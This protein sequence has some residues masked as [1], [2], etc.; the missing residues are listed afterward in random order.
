M[1]IFLKFSDLA[2]RNC[3][4]DIAEAA[5]NFLIGVPSVYDKI[6]AGIL[7]NVRSQSK[8]KQFLFDSAIASK[9]A[10]LDEGKDCPIWNRL[11]LN[12]L[13]QRIG[14]NVR[15]IVSGGAPLSS[16]C[17]DFLRAAFGCP[18]LQGYGL[19]ETCGGCTVGDTSDLQA[20][21]S[22]GPMICSTEIKLVDQTKMNYL[23]T[24]KPCPR[25]E[26]WIRGAN[27]CDGYYKMPEKTQED[28]ID[29]WFKTGD[30]GQLN[31][32]G[33]ISIIDRIKNLVKPPHGEYIAIEK[34]ESMYK[35]CPL[36]SNIMIFA[37]GNSDF[38]VALV[39]PNKAAMEKKLSNKDNLNWHDLCESKPAKELMMKA[40]QD[41]WKEL[42]LKS[43]EKV[44]NVALYPDEWTPDNNWLTAAMKLKRPDIIKDREE[45][46]NVL[47]EEIGSQFK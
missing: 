4:G 33:T 10:A 47:Y 44:S 39:N 32:N 45:D 14:G 18:V 19:T 46:L 25:G 43:I 37:H 27:V 22:A 2:C 40:L 8:I 12:T 38:V 31:Q 13:K 16:Q 20:A 21:Y 41:S 1:V 3:K 36:V 42:G 35:N 23:S 29:G 6:K 24:D 7:A 9:K 15:F 30:I 26:V 34:L 5:P 17:A 28:F 11:V